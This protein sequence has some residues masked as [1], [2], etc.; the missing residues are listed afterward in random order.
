MAKLSDDIFAV[1]DGEVYPRLFTAGEEV[2]G[3]VEIAA[4]DQ[5]KIVRGKA[6]SIKR[7]PENK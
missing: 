4:I 2:F 7:A 5:D 6:K 1:P 3:S